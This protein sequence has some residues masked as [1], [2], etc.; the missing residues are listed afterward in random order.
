MS[1]WDWRARGACRDMAPEIFFPDARDK[2]A[3]E[4]AQRVCSRCPVIRECLEEAF[5]WDRALETTGVWGGATEMQRRRM[6][7][8]RQA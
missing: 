2:K 3:N 4:F 1:G 6:R 7:K 8:A 5:R